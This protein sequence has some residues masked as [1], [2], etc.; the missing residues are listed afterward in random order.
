MNFNEIWQQFLQGM[1]ATTWVEYIA[2]IMGIISVWFS[3]KE[4]VLVYPTGLINTTFY[5]YLSLKAHLMGEAS[6]N[7][8]YTIMSLYGW[9][10]WTRKDRQHQ[11]VLHITKATEKEWGNYLMFFVGAYIVIFAALHYLKQNFAPGAIPWADAL[12][13]ASAYAGMYLMA[14]KKLESWIFWIVTNI[15][16][17][18]LYF[19]KGYVFTSVYYLILL[20][21]AFAGYAAWNKKL[22]AHAR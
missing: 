17:I 5:V 1:Q 14:K 12:A 11:P 13:S 6:V 21:L 20:A 18:P 19:V 16:S 4:N 3:K 22:K 2:V 10:L 8:Y 15:T 7:L 9:Y